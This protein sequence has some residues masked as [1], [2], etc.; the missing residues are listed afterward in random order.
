[1]HVIETSRLIL[2]PY[3]EDDAA[4]MAVLH[5]NPV[6]MDFMKGSKPLSVDEATATFRR[7]LNCW[8]ED[9]YSIFAV[10]RH[11]DDMVIG[12]CGFWHRTDKPGISMRFLL[13]EDHWG[14]GF[15]AEMNEAVTAWLF[16]ATDVQ[17]FWAVTQA[18]NKGAIAILRRL[19][20]DV[21][22]TAHMGIEGLW[23]FDVT[24]PAWLETRA[25]LQD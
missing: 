12:E 20:G 17:S 16:N 25:S 4:A 5:A 1:M 10:R 15:G 22:E 13:H 11:D 8:K 24:R 21:T 7:Y 18:R 19:G 6:V 14:Q 3:V 9:G 23:R 2:K